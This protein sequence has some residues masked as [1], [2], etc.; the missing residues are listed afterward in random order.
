MNKEERTSE[1]TNVQSAVD[2]SIGQITVIVHL[3]H[4]IKKAVKRKI[5]DEVI[6]LVV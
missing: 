6:A 3:T 1:Q 5:S 2:F 4:D